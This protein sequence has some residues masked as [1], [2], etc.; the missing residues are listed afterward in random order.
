MLIHLNFRLPRSLPC[1]CD[2]KSFKPQSLDVSVVKRCDFY[3]SIGTD[4]CFVSLG[5]KTHKN[6][7]WSQM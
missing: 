6:K 1:N 5:K 7:H 2:L 3:V 4:V